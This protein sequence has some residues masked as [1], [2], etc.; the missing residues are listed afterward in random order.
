MYYRP[1]SLRLKDSIKQVG[2]PVLDALGVFNRSIERVRGDASIWTILMYHRVTRDAADDPFGLGMCV[3]L[4][5]FEEQ[6]AYLQRHFTVLPVD[7]VVQRLGRGEPLPPA[8]L[9]IT[10][11]DGYLD[12]LLY[13]QPVLERHGLPWSLYVTTGGL[14]D[15]QAFWW[16]RTIR[17]VAATRADRLDLA[18]LP[19]SFGTGTLSLSGSSRRAAVEHLLETLWGLP[20]A[21]TLV[22]VQA[23]EERLLGHVAPDAGPL[24]PRMST[25]QLRDLASRPGVSIGAHTVRHPNLN[26]LPA[27]EV[28]WEMTASRQALENLLD[29]PIP[30][31]VYPGGRMNADVVELARR[32][33]FR[34]ALSTESHLNLLPADP[35]CLGRVGMPDANVADFR[36]S[37]HS[38][39][40]RV[41]NRHVQ[42]PGS[43][44]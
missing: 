39:A 41:L 27:D 6:I 12:N 16:D 14:D 36:R 17:A 11:D 29:R 40:Q 4:S 1:T 30:G 26:L 28:V 34:Y 42:N 9:S 13:A 5:Y 20:I 38:L 10:F 2:S 32:A 37:L 8:T 7:E 25:E 31:F 24:A 43:G 15:G 22:C 19:E 18:G 3:R 21:R 23:I 44:A 33:G 35:L